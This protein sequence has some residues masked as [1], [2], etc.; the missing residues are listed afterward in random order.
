MSR[1]DDLIMD[2]AERRYLE[3]DDYV[4][5]RDREE[6]IERLSESEDELSELL[7]EVAELQ[8]E[9]KQIKDDL[10]W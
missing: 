8:E 10:G 7:C 9:I 5:K 2:A 3:P 1:L 4:P 6:L